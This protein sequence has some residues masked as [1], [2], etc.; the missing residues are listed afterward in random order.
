MAPNPSF[1][2][3]VLPKSDLLL[4]ELAAARDSYFLLANKSLPREVEWALFKVLNQELANFRHL[5]AVRE[6]CKESAQ[7][8]YR[9]I[10]HLGLGYFN[11]QQY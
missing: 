11:Q 6:L 10:D 5:R 2:K 1:A 3:Q 7:E 8:A 9:L 4:K